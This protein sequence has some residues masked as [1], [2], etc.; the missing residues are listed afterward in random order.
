MHDEVFAKTSDTWSKGVPAVLHSV[1]VHRRVQR[2]YRMYPD[3][4]HLASGDWRLAV[5]QKKRTAMPTY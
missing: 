3:L 2:V 4:G 1:C 5:S